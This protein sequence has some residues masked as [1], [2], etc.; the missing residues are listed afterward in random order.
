MC[1]LQTSY[2]VCTLSLEV[3]YL[4]RY[5]NKKHLILL[6][7]GSVVKV[8]CLFQDHCAGFQAVWF[9]LKESWNLFTSLWLH[10]HSQSISNSAQLC[11]DQWNHQL[12]FLTKFG[13]EVITGIN[14][15]CKMCPECFLSYEVWRK[16][17]RNRMNKKQSRG[18]NW[19]IR[20]MLSLN[21][22]LWFVFSLPMWRSN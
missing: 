1:F 22:C 6:E 10:K 21:K 18:N 16:T 7:V 20:K 12:G 3:F 15:C 11:S 4:S 5:Q 17:N 19:I 14:T 13:H 2:L 8:R 9:C